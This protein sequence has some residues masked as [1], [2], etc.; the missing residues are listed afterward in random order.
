MKG[1]FFMKKN[2]V[3]FISLV[4]VLIIISISALGIGMYSV[5]ETSQQPKDYEL[6]EQSF[7]FEDKNVSQ[8]TP[9]H[10]EELS[11]KFYSMY[12]I[13][14]DE[15]TITVISK[16]YLDDYWESNYEKE[17][18]KTLSVEEILFIIQDSIRIY[19]KYDKIV[20]QEYK[21]KI[22]YGYISISAEFDRRYP[23]SD[24]YVWDGDETQALYRV[25]YIEGETINVIDGYEAERKNPSRAVDS[26]L[27]DLQKIIFYRIEAL[28]SPKAFIQGAE[29]LYLLGENPREFSG[30]Y[31]ERLF[32]CSG[33][34][35]AE[36]REKVM[37]ALIADY[38]K[39]SVGVIDCG[40]IDLVCMSGDYY[41]KRSI[42]SA[43][44]MA[45]K[46]QDSTF[47]NEVVLTDEIKQGVKD[48][49]NDTVSVNYRLIS[50]HDG[51]E[52]ST[53]ITLIP[54]S[55]QYTMSG[56]YGLSSYGTYSIKDETL[57]LI[58]REYTSSIIGR[59]H[60]GRGYVCI[61]P[62]KEDSAIAFLYWSAEVYHN[63]IILERLESSIVW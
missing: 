13:D 30:T 19:E 20:L 14:E 61:V 4:S 21:S 41:S 43:S 22:R 15:N 7:D 1:V 39:S 26:V 24:D 31:P 17:E 25:P 5:G 27:N 32:Y 9:T 37:D 49:L 35:T 53:L 57:R 40:D 23:K 54:K 6:S 50:T 60:G 46:I 12:E 11:E 48:Y 33:M 16:K 56:Y 58:G 47:F 34:K 51:E 42:N 29:Y 38:S 59:E 10:Q 62:L 2:M 8:D 63:D 28:S 55:Q 44:E 45:I 52:C 36:E 3:K 18:I